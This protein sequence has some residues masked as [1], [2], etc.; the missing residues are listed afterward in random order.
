MSLKRILTY[1]SGVIAV[2]SMVLAVMARVFLAD[3]APFG[4]SALSYLRT[5]NTM[6]LFAIAFMIFDYVNNNK[7]TGG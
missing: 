5:T 3:K 4:L 2:I 1:V 7:K 6:L